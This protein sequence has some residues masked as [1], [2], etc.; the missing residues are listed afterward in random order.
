MFKLLSEELHKPVRRKFPRRAVIVQGIDH[1]WSCDLVE[2][3]EWMNKNDG[4]KYML[5]IV[6]VLSKYAWSVPLKNKTAETVVD[7]FQKVVTES[8]RKP[9][10]VWVDEGGEFYNKL[11]DKWLANNKINRYS[12]H[13]D[14]KSANVERFNRTLKTL[15]WKRFT[16]ENTR[17]W[18]DMLPEI[19]KKYNTTV[20]S[21]TGMTPDEASKKKNEKVVWKTLY[22][23]VKFVPNSKAKFKIGDIVRV[24]R[25]KGIFEKGFHPNWSEQLY[26]IDDVLLTNPITYRI[27]DFDDKFIEGTFY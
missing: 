25:W 3:Q 15:M 2:M 16:A 22:D 24:S 5:N 6:D 7:A 18:I 13:G 14:H 23:Y 4:Y 17:R 10:H 20:H 8:K 9:S 19:L 26:R 11:M 21:S 27:K 12:T 1:V